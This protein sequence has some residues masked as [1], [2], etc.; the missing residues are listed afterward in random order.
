MKVRVLAILETMWDWRGATSGAGYRQA[1]A[2]FRINRENFSGKRLHKFVGDHAN[3]LVTN[4]CRELVDH[5]SK[6]GKGDPV[7]LAGN[8]ERLENDGCIDVLLVCGKVAQA[9]FSSCGFTP[10]TPY[11]IHMPHPAARTWNALSL[12]QTSLKIRTAI[13]IQRLSNESN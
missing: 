4:A 12:R 11:I 13:H 7:W 9:T 2:F 3:L 10:Q 6:H 1:P 5:A 8:L